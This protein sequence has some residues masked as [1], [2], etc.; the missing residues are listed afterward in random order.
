[1]SAHTPSRQKVKIKVRNKTLNSNIRTKV[2]IFNHC[3][4]VFESR[5]IFL[6]QMIIF[7]HEQHV[8]DAKYNQCADKL[9][10]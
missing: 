4:L 2:W 10:A 9:E 1:M 8:D 7:L 6:M 5:K 3:F